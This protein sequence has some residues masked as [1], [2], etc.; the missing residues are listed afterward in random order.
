MA[1]HPQNI[2]YSLKEYNNNN[3]DN[4]GLTFDDL[5]NFIEEKELE[6]NSNI[7]Y[8]DNYS[9]CFYWTRI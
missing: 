3:N 2:K 6:L 4:R 1:T 9:E 5:E 8:D 7:N